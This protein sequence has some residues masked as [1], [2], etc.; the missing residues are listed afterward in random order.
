MTCDIYRDNS[1]RYFRDVIADKKIECDFRYKTMLRLESAPDIQNRHFFLKH[2]ALCILDDVENP[3]MYR[4]LAAQYLL[5][6]VF[7]AVASSSAAESVLHVESVI[8]AFAEDDQLDYNLRADAADTLL[9]LGCVENKRRA[10]DVI[11]FLAM[12]GGQVRSVFDNAQNVHVEEIESSVSDALGFLLS[13]PVEKPA[14]EDAPVVDLIFVH[15]AV[16]DLIRK[17]RCDHS[18]H[19]DDAANVSCFYSDSKWAVDIVSAPPSHISFCCTDCE[20][21]YAREHKMLVS[22]NRILID[23]VLYSKFAQTL[24]NILVK[25]WLYISSHES[26]DTMTSRL[27]EELED[28]SGTCSSGFASRLVNV[29]SGFGDFNLRISWA[30]QIVANFIGRINAL[31]RSITEPYSIYFKPPKDREIVELHLRS[32]G[33]IRTADL[34]APSVDVDLKATRGGKTKKAGGGGGGGRSKKKDVAASAAPV[35]SSLVVKTAKEI[36]DEHLSSDR[37]EKVRTAVDSFSESVLAEMTID[38]NRYADKPNFMKFFRDHMLAIREQLYE[39]FKEFVTDT[40][41]DLASRRA[42]SVYE[43]LQHFV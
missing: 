35:P 31:A 39:E 22:L 41:F 30:D 34:T 18:R 12:V 40:E 32:I 36:V 24:G 17:L 1:L 10:R 6:K 14:S 27:L 20:K 37:D 15:A 25:L 7:S 38:I 3:T 11:D 23:R 26:K 21:A 16:R 33:V 28:M 5:Q 42:V 4:I 8:L 2:S 43:G 19:D 13:V 29:I 9:S